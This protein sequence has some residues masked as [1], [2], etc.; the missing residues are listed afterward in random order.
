MEQDTKL[1]KDSVSEEEE[2]DV[3]I[4]KRVDAFLL[5]TLQKMVAMMCVS[6]KKKE[7]GKG[8]NYIEAMFQNVR[9]Q[10]ER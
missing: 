5:G 4:T 8:R 1:A 6:G 9:F 7:Y 3:E 10:D 2:S